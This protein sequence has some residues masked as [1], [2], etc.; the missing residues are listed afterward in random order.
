LSIPFYLGSFLGSLVLSFI[1]T[2]CVR[3]AAT[4]FGIVGEPSKHHIHKEA[5]PRLGGIA[6]YFSFLA[7]TS[8]IVGISALLHT[9]I[10]SSS[11][12]LYILIPGT[13]I[14]LLGLYDDIRP[15]SSYTK[16]A[17]QTVAAVVLFEGGFGVHNLPPLFRSTSAGFLALPL[18]VLWVL[19]LTNAFNLIDG[20][21]GLAAGSALFSTVT[22]FLISQ[23]YGNSSISLLTLALIGSILGFLRF[24]FNPATIFLGDSG[25]LFIGFMLSAFALLGVQQKTSIGI[26]VAIPVVSFGLPIV[27]TVISVMRRLVRGKPLFA[28]DRE[29]IHHKLLEQGLSQRQVVIVLYGVSAVCGLL[30]LFLLYPGTGTAG[31]VL[32]VF[33][34]GVCIGIRQLK[35]HEFLEIGRVAT[36]TIEQPK[37]IRNNLSIRRASEQLAKAATIPE[38]AAI[39]NTAFV[40]ND[41]DGFQLEVDSFSTDD[42]KQVQ[43]QRPAAFPVSKWALDLDL[44]AQNRKVGRFNLWRT[45][46]GQPLLVDINL[47]TTSFQNALS[48]AVDRAVVKE[49]AR[50]ARVAS[51]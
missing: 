45:A 38:I 37:L 31:I 13:I 19:W 36:R 39:L 30:S 46:N 35:Y 27:E 23:I 42:Q 51:R 12:M 8:A 34:A 20:I 28:A 33:G 10:G 32:V 11:A 21:D 3:Y 4:A 9:D 29:H 22:V 18:T 6:I 14:F 48:Q 40:A 15:V 26:A 49:S 25:S 41:F 2:W 44:V 16:L 5:I 47:V 43:W 24:N 7:V 1:L 17:V 50:V